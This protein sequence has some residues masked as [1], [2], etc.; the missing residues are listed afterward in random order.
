M[1][2]GRMIEI[3]DIGREQRQQRAE[4]DREQRV[5]GNTE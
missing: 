3:Q 1:E 5:T 2:I 4:G